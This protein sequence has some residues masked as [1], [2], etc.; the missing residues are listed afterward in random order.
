MNETTTRIAVNEDGTGLILTIEPNGPIILL[1]TLTARV[2]GTDGPGYIHAILPGGKTI[3]WAAH[4]VYS[5]D[6]MLTYNSMLTL[7]GIH[8]I[9]P[10]HQQTDA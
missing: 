7:P 2:Q 5:S 3:K 6:I 1:P 9:E 4:N 10:H 8:S